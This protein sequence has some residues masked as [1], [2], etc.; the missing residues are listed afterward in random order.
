MFFVMEEKY[1]GDPEIYYADS[2]DNTPR[3]LNKDSLKGKTVNNWAATDDA[4]ITECFGEEDMEVILLSADPECKDNV[5]VSD[6]APTDY[7]SWATCDSWSNGYLCFCSNWE[8]ITMIVPDDNG[9]IQLGRKNYTIKTYKLG[10]GYNSAFAMSYS[11]RYLVVSNTDLYANIG[12]YT[13]Y[14][15]GKDSVTE[16]KKVNTKISNPEY[17]TLILGGYFDES[18]GIFTFCRERST[19][20]EEGLS[21]GTYDYTYDI[22]NFFE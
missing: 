2:G 18:T 20:T 3:L 22:I 6:F 7:Y 8:N 16:I 9:D 17:N 21:T 1:G 5:A 13:L 14:E 19:T 10:D 11:G 4:I 15:I 12:N